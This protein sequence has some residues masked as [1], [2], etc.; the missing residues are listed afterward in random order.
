MLGAAVVAASWVGGA[1]AVMN[2]G[3]S[4]CTGAGGAGSCQPKPPE[5]SD[6]GTVTAWGFRP[7]FWQDPYNRY[8]YDSLF[9]GQ[10]GP[11]LRDRL[12]DAQ[13]PGEP[14]NAASR[15][16]DSPCDPVS[17]DTAT[18]AG[19][20]ID[21]SNGNL[22]EYEYDFSSNG[23]M[24]LYL[25]R[26]YASEGNNRGLFGRNWMSNF[27]LSLVKSGDQIVLVRSDRTQIRLS[28]RPAPS[29]GWYIGSSTARVV[30][31]GA[32]GYVY[33][34][35]D[36]SVERY[37]A[38]GQ[39]TRQQNARGIGISFHY[40]AGKLV[41]VT[42]SSGRSIQF[43]WTQDVVTAVTDP[44]G[45]V[46][47]Y[48]YTDF[49]PHGKSLTSATLPG[50][51]PTVQ[52]YRYSSNG[53]LMLSRTVNGVQVAAYTY[54]ISER[55]VSSQRAGG[56]DRYTFTYQYRNGGHLKSTVTNP[57][58]KKT[59]YQFKSG[60]LLSVT[61]HASTFCPS[62]NYREISYDANGHRNLVTDFANGITDYDYDAAGRLLRKVEAAGTP[63]ARETTY[64][65]DTNNRNIRTTIS[66][67]SQTDYVYRDDGLISSM[68]V[69]N[70][71]RIGIPGQTLVTGYGY[72]FHANGMLAVVVEDGPLTGRGDATTR[73]FDQL[74]NLLDQANTLGHTVRYSGH[75]GLG[76]PGRIV[77]VNRE[78]TDLTYDARGRL[79]S[80]T[81]YPNGVAA[82]SL[83]DYDARGRLIRETA[84]DGVITG[85]EYDDANRLT[86]SWQPNPHSAHAHLGSQVRDFVAY[87]HDAA[88]NI[89]L[90]ELG[91][92]YIPS[93]STGFVQRVLQQ[94]HTDYDE[95]GRVRARRGNHGQHTRFTYD[96]NGN[97]RTLT[98]SLG[99]VTTY[100][101]DVL[102]RVDSIVL[103][104]NGGVVWYGYDSMGNRHYV[105]DARGKATWSAYDGLGQL[106][107]QNSPDTGI[108]TFQYN[109]GGQRSLMRRSDGSEL[110][111]RYDTLGRLIWAGT[112]SEARAYRWDSCSNGNLRLCEVIST[113]NGKVQT[114]S[115]FWYTRQ[116]QLS[117]RSDMLGPNE[118]IQ[119][120]G[121]AYDSMGRTVGVSYPSGTEVGYG[122]NAGR[123]SLMQ[124]SV[125]GVT[126]RV[127]SDLQY[128]AD[129]RLASLRYGNGVLKERLY[130]SDGRVQVLHDHGWLGHT[131][132]YDANDRI[133][134]IENWSRKDFN[135]TYRYDALSRMTEVRSP[136][137][138]QVLA[139]DANGN[140][141]AHRWTHPQGAVTDLRHVIDPASNRLLSEQIVYQHDQRGN[142]SS[143]QTPD[144]TT[145]AYSYDGFNRLKTVN[146]S[147]PSRYTSADARSDHLLPAGQTRYT[148]NALDQRVAK[149]S[150]LGTRHF[151]YDQQ[152]R[153]LMEQTGYKQ[154]DTLWL[155][156]EP[157]AVVR[158]QQLYFLHNDHLGRPEIVTDAENKIAWG[159]ANGAFD[160]HVFRT[161][162]F[163]DLNLGFPGQYFDAET[164][165][166]HNGYRD[167]DSRTGRYLQSDPLGLAGGL[168][169]YAY[170][171]ANPVTHVDPLGLKATCKCTDSGAEV[172]INFKFK[173]DGASDATKISAFRSAI[174][175]L[176]SAPG[177]KVTTSIGGFGA[178]TINLASGSGRSF[179]RGNRGTWYM[180]ADPWVGAHEAGHI[181]KLDDKYTEPTRGHAIPQPGWENTIM[182]Q[183]LGA[184][185]PADR[186]GVLDALDCN[187]VCGGGR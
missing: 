137:G 85:Y 167:Y 22:L 33:Y 24:P 147:G 75:N 28:P 102:N 94:S 159:A 154:S 1:G 6:G 64:V 70:L 125:E 126:R 56:L 86:K 135:Q 59:T 76:L 122:Y 23:E 182:A 84:A 81:T 111:N 19:D 35:A 47:R 38:A 99:N 160:R 136:T 121:Y 144:G 41:Q 146:A 119:W 44:S 57:L 140:R 45:Q 20:P 123:L 2:A 105:A 78:Q 185:T 162:A 155:G 177:F 93:G 89:T 29:S 180:D 26:S 51:Q 65:Y 173:G 184:V 10:S 50:D 130:D 131:Q 36:N 187:C 12:P 66:G 72:R 166:W 151:L 112:D 186:Q 104:G 106:W 134:Q 25:Q 109:E 178:T 114:A 9:R 91:V 79:R 83:R 74:G 98:D 181:M 142:R 100:G 97:L 156:N 82:T 165:F 103:P 58:G 3:G 14:V 18:L 120:T 176:W 88:G 55:A 163:G 8:I 170:A 21:Y 15:T 158:N 80:L 46:Y 13:A 53:T 37:N 171:G 132:H 92:E 175:N 34:A 7:P 87:S 96:A 90:T 113:A 61:G 48:A 77:G 95:L 117:L 5:P 39:I 116:G 43:A 169:T 172:N 157:I 164:G 62:S 115:N 143:Q 73:R 60:R 118:P 27:D 150:P 16:S 148:V 108:T 32:G 49:P 139:Y 71:A 133:T 138:E 179:M 153:L 67:V 63:M 152:N 127:V 42:H 11:Y 31:D 17:Q 129:G 183:H 128:H 149:Q 40:V 54:G 4:H 68:A 30:G 145:T 141:S 52:G 161:T 110:A 101:Y 69:K 168:N 107:A 124:A 174:E